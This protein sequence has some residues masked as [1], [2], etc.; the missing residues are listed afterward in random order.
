MLTPKAFA[1][2]KGRDRFDTEA[3]TDAP[4]SAVLQ[5]LPGYKGPRMELYAGSCAKAVNEEMYSGGFVHKGPPRKIAHE[6][7]AKLSKRAMTR[8]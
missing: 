6:I 4:G 7:P 2:S 1:P 8:V 5:V 3:A